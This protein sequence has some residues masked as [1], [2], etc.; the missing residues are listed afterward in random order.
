M[1][2]FAIIVEEVYKKNVKSVGFISMV[3]SPIVIL[4]IIGA[5]IYFVGSSFSEPPTIALITNDQE[6]RTALEAETE[7]FKVAKKVTSIVEA[8]KQMKA[9]KLDGY[10]E[11]AIENDS[12]N[13]N[14]VHTSSGQSLDLSS[15]QSVLSVTQLNRTASQLGLTEAEV[16]KLMAPAKLDDRVIRFEGEN[17]TS[18]N[19]QD[20]SIK[21]WS[22]YVVGIAVF[23][24]IINYASIIAQ[25]IAS[26]KGTRIMEIILSSVSSSVHFFGKLVGILLVCLTQV[27]IYGVIGLVAYQFGQSFEPVQQVL[28][29][30]DI[31]ELLQGLLG[32][33]IVYFVLGIILYAAIAA[34]LGSLVSKIEDVNKAVT[35]LVFLSMIG[36]YGGMFAFASPT[37]M[38]VKIASYVPFFTPMI[39]PFRVA[40]ET[41]ST[42]GNLLS[43]A[44]M[45]IFTILCSYVSLMLYRSNVLV[46]SDSGMFKTMKASWSIMRN[47]KKKEA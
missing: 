29:G 38:I 39:M 40:S 45:V 43:I 17:I 13:G 46:Y 26:E 28:Q 11:I 34:F 30:I 16:A 23:I 42:A 9:E 32:Y 35:P 20:T 41:V 6:I 5:V 7:E 8:E 21:M 44:L 19:D 47:E 31:K 37:Q 22:A 3:L 25:E 24:F 14:Y 36:F 10:L 15:L 33:S 12:I 1:N 27:V 18:Q 4:L 2:K